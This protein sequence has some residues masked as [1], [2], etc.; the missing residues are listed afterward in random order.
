MDEFLN[1][2][3]YAVFIQYV[4][5]HLNQSTMTR[6]KFGILIE[7]H[8][9][10][11]TVFF[12]RNKIMEYQVKEEE[13]ISYYLHCHFVNFLNATQLFHD[14]LTYL[15]KFIPLKVL[16]CC[17][18]AL[19]SSYLVE[20]LKEYAQS[21]HENISYTACSYNRILEAEYDLILLAPQIGY[22]RKQ[23][24]KDMNI[25]VIPT[26]L[27]ATYDYGKITDMIREISY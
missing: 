20:G 4:Y 13:N 22:L 7:N 24:P 5:Q 10:H 9:Y 26:Q 8:D 3:Q 12:T 19:T 15:N 18:S 21:H 14:F 16:I 23:L 6:D 17:S 11:Y 2:I 1:D 27:Y 25:K